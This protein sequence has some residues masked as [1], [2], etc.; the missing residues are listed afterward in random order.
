MCVG[1]RAAVFRATWGTCANAFRHWS[2]QST[3]PTC[4]GK[5][6]ASRDSKRRC[7][8]CTARRSPRRRARLVMQP[9]GASSYRKRHTTTTT[10]VVAMGQTTETGLRYS[11]STRTAAAARPTSSTGRPARPC[12]QTLCCLAPWLEFMCDGSQMQA[13]TR[14]SGRL[15]LATCWGRRSEDEMSKE[16]ERTMHLMLAGH[17]EVWI[18][19]SR[20]KSPMAQAPC[21]EQGT[22]RLGIL[23]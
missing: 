14:Y 6:R 10:A 16:P 9:A 5:G 20:S 1:R 18:T 7:W 11:L 23:D 4:E 8:C 22:T 19:Y 15:L 13:S 17:G 12:R 21:L 2:V 3:P